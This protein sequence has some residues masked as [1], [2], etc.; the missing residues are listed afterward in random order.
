MTIVAVAQLPLLVGE[1]DANTELMRAAIVSAAEAG[2]QL[3]VLPE[4][5]QSGF[6][7][8][9]RAEAFVL[10]ETTDGPA[11]RLWQELSIAHG[12]IVVGGFC[13][14]GPD[15]SVFNSAAIVEGGQTLAIYRKVH[16]WDTEKLVFTPGD[17][18]SP[19]VETSI[20]RVGVMICYDLEFPEWSRGV[21]LDGADLLAAPTNWPLSPRPDGER[22]MEVVR[23]QANAS[24]NR[25]YVAAADRCRQE[26]GVDWV[27]G[28]VI[29]DLDGFPVAGPI[30]A[31]RAGILYADLDLA[32][33]RDKQISAR[34]DVHADRRPELY[35]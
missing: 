25:M 24:A 13:E 15:G 16:L 18:A 26:R 3:V 9:D 6:V 4:L 23:V 10:S 19:V 17:A 20:G 31:D 34:N 35:A 33:A 1:L 5:A 12:V 8:T 30:A 22:P 29:V 7:F 11:V 21:G 27:G 32:A 28:S 14:T 2:A